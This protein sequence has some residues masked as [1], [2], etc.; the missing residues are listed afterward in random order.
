MYPGSGSTYYIRKWA[1]W[2]WVQWPTIRHNLHLKRILVENSS[3]TS[4]RT[5][6]IFARPHD[7][8]LFGQLHAFEWAGD[9]KKLRV[10]KTQISLSLSLSASLS[11]LSFLWVR[12][13]YKCVFFIHFE[14][15]VD[16]VV[17]CITQHT[18]REE[19]ER[20]KQKKKKIVGIL[21]RILNFLVLFFLMCLV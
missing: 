14:A 20:K 2:F 8:L 9:P 16:I 17:A 10:Q 18:Q 5:L 15:L 21:L 3:C 11:F 6:W 13:F 1:I 19:E 12:E 7:V 4:L